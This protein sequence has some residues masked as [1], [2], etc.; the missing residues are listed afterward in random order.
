MHI[1]FLHCL[2]LVFR[3]ID[4]QALVGNVGGYIGLCLGYNFLQIPG[5]VLV[6][7]RKWRAFNFL[8]K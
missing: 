3:A 6:M 8:S 2:E 4:V 7:F 1:Y 5:L